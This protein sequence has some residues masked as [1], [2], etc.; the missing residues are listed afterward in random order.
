MR[1][2][3]QNVDVAEQILVHECVVAL[4]V[5]LRQRN[6]LVHV[7]RDLYIIDSVIVL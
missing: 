5:V 7:E 4:G 3:R 6:I 1:V 2:F